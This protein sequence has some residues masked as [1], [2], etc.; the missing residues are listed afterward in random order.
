MNALPSLR[1]RL[2]A[3]ALPSGFALFLCFVPACA[4]SPNG[5]SPST[6]ATGSALAAAQARQVLDYHN[7]VR[8]EAGAGPLA[9]SPEIARY[10]QE[11][12]ETIARTRRFAHLP[13]GRNP[14]GENLAQGGGGFGLLEACEGWHAERAMMPRGARTMTPDLFRRGVGHYTQMV[15]GESARIGA[16]MARYEAGGTAWTVVVCCYDPPGNAMGREILPKP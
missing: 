11:R 9:W 14:Y 8:A 10:A 12:A 7:R 15:W 4:V 6:E 5:S 1:K 16:G 2:R 3:L 13:L